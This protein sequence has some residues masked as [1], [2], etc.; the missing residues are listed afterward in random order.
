[1]VGSEAALASLDFAHLTY[2]CDFDK[3]LKVHEF[4]LME[5]KFL[6]SEPFQ[7]GFSLTA[8]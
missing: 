4:R 2:E 8:G 7:A 6:Q 1:M 3:S 5:D